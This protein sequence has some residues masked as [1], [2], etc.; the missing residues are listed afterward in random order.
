MIDEFEDRAATKDLELTQGMVGGTHEVSATIV[1]FAPVLLEAGLLLGATAV[2]ITAAGALVADTWR[3]NNAVEPE[4][5]YPWKRE[6]RKSQ[7][8]FA[9]DD[10]E[11]I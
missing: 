3:L 5:L 1:E 2:W 8:R 4:P 9:F 10:W 7:T 6:G 11:G